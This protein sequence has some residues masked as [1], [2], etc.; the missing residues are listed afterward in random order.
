MMI[1]APY[2][3][4]PTQE[5]LYAHFAEVAD[6]VDAELMVYNIP[7]FTGVNVDPSTLGRLS[8]IENIVAVKEEAELNPKQTTEYLLSTPDE[9]IV[10]CGD[11]TMISEAFI[12][13]GGKRIGGVVSGGSHIASSLVRD[14]ISNVVEGDSSK[15]AQLQQRFLPVLRSMGQNGR[16]NP[17]ALLK[18]AMKLQGLPAG[19]PRQPLLPGT[20]EEIQNVRNAMKAAGLL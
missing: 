16:T 7:I 9:F 17:V 1:V 13:G 6:K 3:T 2:Y 18:E 19:F 20:D 5:E 15:A 11:D 12:Q 14:I 4:K 8:R 10:Y